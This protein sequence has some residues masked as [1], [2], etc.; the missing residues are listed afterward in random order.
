M[1]SGNRF[2]LSLQQR[3]NSGGHKTDAVD[4]RSG[5]AARD[6]RAIVAV[7]AVGKRFRPAN[8]PESP[9]APRD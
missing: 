1:L 4:H 9:R 3:T 2:D 6:E 5:L 7:A 8:E